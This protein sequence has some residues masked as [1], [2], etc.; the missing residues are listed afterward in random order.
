[1]FNLISNLKYGLDFGYVFILPGRFCEM[2]KHSP[3]WPQ[4]V[5]HVMYT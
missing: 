1:M 5:S 3:V 2:F 4:N